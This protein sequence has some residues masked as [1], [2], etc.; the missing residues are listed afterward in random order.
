MTCQVSAAFSNQVFV[1]SRPTKGVLLHGPLGTGKTSLVK[2]SNIISQYCDE[3]EQSL[4][5]VF[6]SAHQVAPSVVFIDEF[7]VIA[8]TRKDGNEEMSKGASIVV[9][10]EMG[11][12]INSKQ[13]LL[14]LALSRSK[15]I[16]SNKTVS[17][18][19]CLYCSTK[20]TAGQERYHSLAPMSYRGAAATII[21]YDI[22]DN[23]IVL[24]LSFDF[25]IL[26]ILKH[27]NLVT[28][29][30][31]LMRMKL[32]TL[33][34]VDEFDAIAPARKDGNEELSKGASIVVLIGV[35]SI[36][37]IFTLQPLAFILMTM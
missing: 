10:N 19:K 13:F 31:S 27:V 16:E 36:T 34:T 32:V 12:S 26:N 35:L 5:K 3:S 33:Y 18:F 1:N 8:P 24:V 4:H 6:D 30:V 9:Q 7:D 22:T 20:D 29:A 23:P 37:E 25:E 28:A 17:L 2:V 14:T 15:M 21:M 11:I